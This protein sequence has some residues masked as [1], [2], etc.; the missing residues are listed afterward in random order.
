LWSSIHRYPS[1]QRFYTIT[2]R[3][4]GGDRTGVDLVSKVVAGT[5]EV[6]EE[7]VLNR[8]AVTDPNWEGLFL[9]AQL[10]A[11]QRAFH[12]NAGGSLSEPG[13]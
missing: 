5:D 11:E 4:N 6:L 2:A 3:A 1:Q 13:A 8:F 12:L 10:E 7:Q 9:S